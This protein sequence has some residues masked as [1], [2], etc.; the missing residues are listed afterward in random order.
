MMIKAEQVS[1][2]EVANYAK[3]LYSL[4]IPNPKT[5]IAPIKASD[6]NIVSV[7]FEP[8]IIDHM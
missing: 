1:V 3:C 6:L 2:I 8:A 4:Q 7:V 5:T